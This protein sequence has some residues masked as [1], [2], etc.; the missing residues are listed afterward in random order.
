MNTSK[1]F[2]LL[3]TLVAVL[4]IS[5]AIVTFLGTTT[6]GI[7]STRQAV[8]QMVAQSLAQEGMELVIALRNSNFLNT[9]A[10]TWDND[11]LGCT[12]GCAMDPWPTPS[13]MT[14]A[15]CSTR[16]CSM[17]YKTPTG[18]YTHSAA[19]TNVATPFSRTITIAPDA[20][21]TGLVVISRV[22]WVD[23][24]IMREVEF[25]EFL[26]NWFQPLPATTPTLPGPVGNNPVVQ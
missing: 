1:G 3:E 4:L 16:A 14:I 13:Q 15:A 26:T 10:V 25:T 5:L 9:P 20:N 12:T 24:Q 21:A 17:L 22:Q 2:T 23:R 6:S 18:K 7:R 19:P 8:N 11:M